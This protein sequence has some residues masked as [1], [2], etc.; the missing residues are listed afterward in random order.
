MSTLKIP[1]LSL[2]ALI[3][4]SGA[5]KST[6]ARQHFLPT[7]VI[8]SDFCRGLVG[9]DEND[10]AVTKDA[11]DVLYAEGEERPKMMSVGLHARI[12]GRPGKMAGL[13]RFLRYALDH[14][15][16]WFA[17]RVEIAKHWRERH[18]HVG[19]AGA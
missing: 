3:G 16:V 6:F 15:D 12:V 13:E 1:H 11:F 19:T 4:P 10:Q 9:D 5:G 8:S 2:V 7:E 14:K 17:R 18:P